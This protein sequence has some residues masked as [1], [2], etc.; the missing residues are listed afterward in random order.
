M[1]PPRDSFQ[2]ERYTQTKSKGLEKD[3]SCTRKRKQS[4]G[5]STYSDKI[6]FKKIEIISSIFSDNAM[7]L[8]INHMKNTEKHTKTWKLKTCH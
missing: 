1:L 7:K 8:E 3:T 2:M 4:W 6:D 5:S